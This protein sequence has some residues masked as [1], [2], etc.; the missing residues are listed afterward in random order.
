MNG[1]LLIPIIG[2]LLI[3]AFSGCPE[4]APPANQGNG[5]TAI[6]GPV[7]CGT[8]KECFYENLSDCSAATTALSEQGTTVEITIEGFE[9]DKC[10]VSNVI[11]AFPIP[12]LAG[13]EY[14][15]KIPSDKLSEQAFDNWLSNNLQNECTGSFVDALAN[16]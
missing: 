3:L 6:T 7:D 9:G 11:T 5:N 14:T 8:S 15:C 16:L 2:F 1:I 4:P 12:G 13:L 10:V